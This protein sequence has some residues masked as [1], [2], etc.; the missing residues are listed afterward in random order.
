MDLG[1]LNSRIRAWSSR[2]LT[3]D[4][5]DTF[6]SA[7]DIKS[8]INHLKETAYVRDIE[9]AAAR[10][11]DEEEIIEGGLK[12]NLTKTLKAIWDYAPPDARDLIHS[13]FA[14]WEVYN[15]KAILRARDK[16]ISADDSLSVLMPVGMT[17]ESALKE[18]NQ[19]KDITGVISLL[20]S[21]ASPYASPIRKVFQQYM[22]EKNLMIIETALDRFVHNY[23]L[24][25]TAGN[26][27]N[28][29]IIARFLRQRIDS[30]NISTILKLSGEEIS[31]AN[32][33]EYFLDKGEGIDRNDFLR[34]ISAKNK[35]DVLHGL[36]DAVRD[37]R[38]KRLISSAEPDESFF[39]EEQIEEL[40]RQNICRL[41][42]VEPLSIALTLCFIYKKIR[43]VKN[44][45]LIV[46][47]KIFNMPA[48]EVKRFI[49]LG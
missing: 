1:Y 22:L 25:I 28:N 7:G 27:L 18:L 43:E 10:Y 37:G 12:G 26:N 9:I 48:I 44:L 29:V 5:Y 2:L 31:P 19:Q 33:E 16:G 39:L 36:A 35:K 21:W 6:I 32:A 15:L 8:L 38:C 14:I 17:D 30:I 41:A 47:A 24:S 46:R 4:E 3:A 23:I 34:I 20:S 49:I 45:R 42:V 11:A 13:V 40:S